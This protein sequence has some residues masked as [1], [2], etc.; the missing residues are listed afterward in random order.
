MHTPS[1]TL[2][3]TARASASATACP[4]SRRHQRVLEQVLEALGKPAGVLKVADAGCGDGAQCRLWAERGHQAFGADADPAQVALAR[5]L[6]RAARLDIVFEV[7]SAGTLPWLDG[8]MDV[9]LA[10]QQFEAGE[11]L[12]ASLA[13]LVRVLKPG[14]LL[15]FCSASRLDPQQHACYLGLLQR[16]YD[17]LACHRFTHS[18]RAHLEE[19]GMTGLD[20]AVKLTPAGGHE[21]ACMLVQAVPPLRQCAYPGAPHA[22]LLA[23]KRR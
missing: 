16:G 2:S 9:C 15:Y 19:L 13:E 23:F 21:G 17:A 4:A 6:A 3:T 22:G 20:P 10:P 12:R 14:A 7:G 5:K 8:S 1:T 18:L 11:A